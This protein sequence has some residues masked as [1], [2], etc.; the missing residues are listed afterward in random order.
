[1]KY[2]I[3]F[4]LIMFLLP[5]PVYDGSYNTISGLIWCKTESACI[6]ERGHKLDDRLGWISGSVGF[7]AAIR[8]Q[9]IRYPDSQTA[10]MIITKLIKYDQPVK[11]I[12]ATIYEQ[13]RGNVDQIPFYFQEY[14]KEIR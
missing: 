14:Y 9:L 5:N 13:A 10:Q 7:E 11:E 1:M 12:Y 4:L 6:H 2:F 3:C 8:A